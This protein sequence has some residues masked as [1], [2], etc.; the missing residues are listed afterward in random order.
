MNMAGFNLTPLFRVGSIL[1]SHK[2]LRTRLFMTIISSA[3]QTLHGFDDRCSE[4]G[5]KDCIQGKRT[6]C[7]GEV[8]LRIT[9]F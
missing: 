7:L 8:Y 3:H 4:Q 1:G 2:Y 6:D 9:V 5:N